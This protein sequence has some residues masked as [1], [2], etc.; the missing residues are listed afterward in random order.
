MVDKVKP[1]GLENSSLG[2]TENVPLPTEVDPSEDY[3]AAKGL[4]GENSDTNL[5]DLSASGEWQWRDSVQTTPKKL[6]DIA[7][8]GADNFSYHKIDVDLTLSIAA[9][10]SMITTFLEIDGFLDL[11][12]GLVFL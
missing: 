4:S 2:G 8:S 7:T 12:G 3:L 5:F 10:Q 6:N 11:S 1:L 9:S